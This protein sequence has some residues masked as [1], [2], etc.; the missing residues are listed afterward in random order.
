MDPSIDVIIG[1]DA[2]VGPDLRL[3]RDAA[4][5]VRGERIVAAAPRSEVDPPFDARF[6]D[7]TGKT[8]VPGF[9]DAHVHIGFYDPGDVVRGGVTTARDLA[10][11][12]G[13]IHPLV[14]RSR[15]ASFDGPTLVAA[16]PMLT[17]AGGYPT[18]AAWA[19]PGTGRIVRG[20]EDAGDVVRVTAQEGA[21]IIKVALN[22]D[23]GP[24]L[25]A[26]TLT[27]IVAAAHDR[28]LRVTAHASR[29]AEV[30]KA[31]HCG[32]DELAHMVLS[33]ERIP[34]GSL[35]RMVAA[36]LTIVPTLSILAGRVLRAAV[37]NLTRFRAA[38]GR[39]VYGTDLGNAG[40]RPGIDGREIRAMARAGM[41]SL[42][43]V[44]SATTISSAWLGLDDTGV[45]EGGRIADIAALDGDLEDVGTLER[46]AMVWRRGVRVR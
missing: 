36:D 16:G 6:I 11:P 19:P 37:D 41:S 46:V 25:D 22:P 7:A 31:L 39:V 21:A 26:P 5:M 4:V 20:P 34:D 43:I 33:A 8:L 18:R 44:K 28:G 2:L 15:S 45:L 27:A 29:V 10:W 32:V 3:V 12:P 14:E 38:G 17:V 40:P 1:G 42:D 23:A 9:I 13:D 30:E 24:V 35:E